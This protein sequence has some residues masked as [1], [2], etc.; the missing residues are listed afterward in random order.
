MKTEIDIN[1]FAPY[2]GCKKGENRKPSFYGKAKIITENGEQVLVS[3]GTKVCKVNG[4]RFI[5]L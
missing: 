1:K 4:K 5:R 3:Y 2:H